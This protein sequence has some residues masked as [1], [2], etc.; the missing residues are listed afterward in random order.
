M[1][2]FACHTVSLCKLQTNW[3]LQ[4][5]LTFFCFVVMATRKFFPV[6]EFS[7]RSTS[8]WSG[9]T[10]TS[11]CL[12]LLGEKNSHGLMCL[13]Q[14]RNRECMHHVSEPIPALQRD[15]HS[16][17]RGLFPLSN[18]MAKKRPAD[19]L[20]RKPLKQTMYECLTKLHLEY[21]K[22]SFRFYVWS[23]TSGLK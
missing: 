21:R 22:Y 5:K 9:V 6:W 19:L 14:V 20:Y 18:K 8:S 13:L 17:K 10:L 7:W 12:C 15:S 3:N 4:V 23:S 2:V 11:Q 1:N 16:R